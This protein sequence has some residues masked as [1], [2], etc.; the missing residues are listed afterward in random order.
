MASTQTLDLSWI[1]QHKQDKTKL[2]MGNIEGH[3]ITPVRDDIRKE[4]N[5][6]RKITYKQFC[7]VRTSGDV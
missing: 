1:T 5:L 3:D 7:K 6:S 2:K 4:L